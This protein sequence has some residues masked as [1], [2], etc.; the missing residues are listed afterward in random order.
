MFSFYKK[1]KCIW[2]RLNHNVNRLESICENL[3]RNAKVVECHLDSI[4]QIFK[5][6]R[7]YSTKNFNKIRIGRNQDGG[8]IF[9]DDFKEVNVVFSFGISD[10]DSADV[11]FAERNLKVL[12]FDHTVNN[13]PTKHKNCEFFK[14]KICPT[15][16]PD[17]ISI[18]EC[19]KSHTKNFPS[20]ILKMDIEDSE[21][22]VLNSTTIEELSKF[23]QICVEYHFFDRIG[24]DIRFELVRNVLK[25]MNKVFYV[26]HIHGNN[27]GCVFTNHNILIPG[28]LEVTYVNR[29]IYDPVDEKV[30]FPIEGLDYPNDPSKTDYQLGC[31]WFNDPKNNE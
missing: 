24:C 14:K 20:I 21:W 3:E 9:L 8:Y 26:S 13:A 11:D 15:G 5:Y 16:A 2:H 6:L 10:E 7:P 1:A 25:K 23:R 27:Y 29:S 30:I 17:G 18:S 22:E 4:L 19:L 31:F 28:T 12:Q